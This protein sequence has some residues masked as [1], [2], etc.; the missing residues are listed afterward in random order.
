M[1]DPIDQAM[2]ERLSELRTMPVDTSRV[3]ARIEAQIGVLVKSQSGR[4]RGLRPMRAIAASI[5]L[6]IALSAAFLV[7]SARPAVA[8]AQLMAQMH[9]D[10]V[11]GRTP[12][13]QVDSIEEASK[14][15]A[16]QAQANDLPSLPN[17][18]A[19][20][21]MACCMKSVK[22]K[23]VC[24]VLLKS[25]GGVPVTMAVAN[26]ED[27]RLAPNSPTVQRGGVTYRAESFQQ[28]QMISAQREGRWVCLIGAVPAGQLMDIAEK[29]QF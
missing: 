10:L 7:W 17:V 12:V 11:S 22:H 18:P 1:N 9:E 13:T 2:R 5:V 26:G 15:L 6:V 28:L 20:H 8:S 25:A 14:Q 23:K 21:V 16:Q 3:A 4:I 29:L 27:M 19:E 24:C